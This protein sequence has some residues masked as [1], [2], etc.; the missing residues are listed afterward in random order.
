MLNCAD[1]SDKKLEQELSEKKKILQD[2]EEKLEWN[3]RQREGEKK[4]ITEHLSTITSHAETIAEQ[5][6]ELVELRKMVATYEKIQRVAQCL[7]CGRM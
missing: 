2:C 7:L 6:Q 3:M 5:Q 1:S 4:V